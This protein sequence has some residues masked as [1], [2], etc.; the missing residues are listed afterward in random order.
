MTRGGLWLLDRW[1]AAPALALEAGVRIDRSGVN[2]DTQ[3]SPRVTATWSLDSRTRLRTAL[4]RY[5]QSPGYEKLV[6]SDYVLDLTGDQ[7][8]RLRSEQA[9][10]LSAGL[11]RDIAGAATL[12][13]EGYYKTSSRLLVGRL[14]TE[15]ERQARRRRVR[16]SGRA[17]LE[18]AGGSD[19]HVDA[20]QRR[21]RPRVRL[22]RVRLAH[23][24]ASGCPRARLGELHMGTRDT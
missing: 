21:P 15:A 17:R 4:G 3:V 24:R 19:H 20:D 12:R 23:D 2:R 1:Q 14:E 9:V 18:R 11:E 10:Q 5:T 8:G 6:Q 22:R 13:I 16:L 7:V